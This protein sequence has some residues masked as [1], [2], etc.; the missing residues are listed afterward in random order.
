MLTYNCVRVHTGGYLGGG[1]NE[2]EKWIEC[3]YQ[4]VRGTIATKQ[5]TPIKIRGTNS[6]GTIYTLSTFVL[7]PKT[8]TVIIRIFNSKGS[9]LVRLTKH[10]RGLRSTTLKASL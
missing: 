10:Q 3:Y 5:I 4:V 9:H 7:Y 1:T 2:D 6:E 8:D